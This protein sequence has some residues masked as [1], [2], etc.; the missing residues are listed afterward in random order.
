MFS[1][2]IFALLL[3]FTH[4]NAFAIDNYRELFCPSDIPRKTLIVEKGQDAYKLAQAHGNTIETLRAC[5]PQCDLDNIQPG[6]PIVLLSRRQVHEEKCA[7]HKMYT[8]NVGD[9]VWDLSEALGVTMQDIADCN[10]QIPSMLTC[11]LIEAGQCIRIPS[12][13]Y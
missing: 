10:P 5:N 11:N 9:T 6:Q 12:V 3:L 13:K 4:I 7:E 8:V 1:N 2:S